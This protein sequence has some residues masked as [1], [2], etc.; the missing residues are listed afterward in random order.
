MK[1]LLSIAVA[2][3]LVLAFS[4]PGTAAQRPGAVVSAKATGLSQTAVS[5]RANLK[6]HRQINHWAHVNNLS[7]AVSVPS[8]RAVRKVRQAFLAAQARRA[9]LVKAQR[10]QGTALIAEAQ[11]NGSLQVFRPGGSQPYSSISRI[12]GRWS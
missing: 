11:K 3:G 8:I 9:W 10:R 4:A 7:E 2:L 6:L 1:R 5:N 12:S